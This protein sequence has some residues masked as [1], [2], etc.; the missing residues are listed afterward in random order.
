MSFRPPLTALAGVCLALLS[1]L[2]PTC[3]AL[4]Q[5]ASIASD[6]PARVQ[7]GAEP[8]SAKPTLEPSGMIRLQMDEFGN[9]IALQTATKRFVL[10]D[11]N[12]NV[13]L[14]V[15][16]ESV[17]HIADTSYYREFQQRFEHYDSVLYELVTDQP[18]RLST[19][20]E[21]PN[22]F[23]LFRQISIGSL[24]LAYQLEAIDYTPKN[25]VHAD[26]SPSEMADR[27]ANRGETKTTLLI[28]LFAHIIKTIGA[29]KQLDDSPVPAER[30]GEES[31]KSQRL[32]LSVLTDPDG[33]MKIRRIMA[34]NLVDSQLLDSVFP[35]SIHRLLI[36]DRNDRV[37]SMLN[38]E[39]QK[40][41]HRIAIFYGAGHM[42]DFERRLTNEYGL[43]LVDVNWR[44]A[45]DLRNGAVPGGPLEGLIESTFRDSIK[46]KLSQWAKGR[47]RDSVAEDSEETAD[48]DKDA[49]IRK[50]EE[51]L[52][53]LENKLKRLEIESQQENKKTPDSEQSSPDQTDPDKGGRE[54]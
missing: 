46:E 49:E 32:E 33:I 5:D 2:I 19:D 26:L 3:Q 41:K 15:I 24:G 30:E 17:I 48:S 40:G 25:M 37:M 47:G 9:P 18:E 20:D 1:G 6:S 42:P 31:P 22:G 29:E 53:A 8:T 11:K 38:A 16:L 36:T 35:P 39:R 7:E 13:E 12:G 28:D 21:L 4:P 50:L 14:E 23:Q 27:M 52:K 54:G 43:E 45:W 44:S 51:T 34:L 10:K